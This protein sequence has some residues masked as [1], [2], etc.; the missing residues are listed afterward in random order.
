MSYPRLA[1]R[2]YNQPLVIT[3]E[4]LEV[5]ERVFR[6]YETGAL[7]SAKL[8]TPEAPPRPEVAGPGEAQVT[9]AGYVRTADGMAIV[10]VLG[11]L[12]Q[13]G[14]GMDAMSGLASYEQ[15]GAQLAAAI[16]DPMVHGVLL[17]IDSPGGEVPGV[18]DLGNMIRQL[19]DV[20]PIVA[21]AN[22]MAL[23]GGY[24]LASAADE[25]YAPKTGLVGSIGVRM[26]HVD[27]SGYDAKRGIVYT[28]I[29]A[30]ARKG[31]FSPH[32]PLSDEARQ[33]AQEHVNHTY[34]IFVDHVSRMRGIEPDAVKAT[35]AGVFHAEQGVE[36]GLIDG[37]ATV[38]E[39]LG[40]L[41]SRVASR[42]QGE[43]PMRMAAQADRTFQS[44]AKA[45]DTGAEDMANDP[46]QPAAAALTP[47]DLADAEVRGFQQ[48]KAEGEKAVAAARSEG[49][50]A[51]QERIKSI[52]THPEAEGRRTLA[53]HFAYETDDSVEKV[54]AAL[55][56]A[57]KEVKAT[58]PANP[59]DA[60]MRATG[61]P[62]VG[63][64]TPADA[65]NEEE[66]V[67]ALAASIINAG[68]SGKT[69]TA[70]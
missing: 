4:K 61:N 3:S 19:T 63:A 59:L 14:S 22:E 70:A 58:A 33:W 41:R 56:K 43:S 37:V 35:E 9:R 7:S 31:D 23:S 34:E 68:R 52:L 32:E 55:A 47:T 16:D 65:G 27:Q 26:A 8:M 39:T 18:F 49:A 50:K 1:A 13:R 54:A 17:E 15:I 20:K 11:T 24:I 28:E 60:A 53:E 21:H 44:S 67:R 62:Q 10:S 48:G 69:R 30:G 64:D 36:L 57:P 40:I 12:V 29:I 42:E 66:S 38:G 6:M 25:V 2:L 5:I 51:A 46:K 45:D